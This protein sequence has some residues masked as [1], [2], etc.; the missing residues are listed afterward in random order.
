M[1]TVY[2]YPV[3]HF[4]REDDGSQPIAGLCI[5]SWRCDWGS[6]ASCTEHTCIFKQ[7][8]INTQSC[9][10]SCFWL[11]SWVLPSWV[12]NLQPWLFK[13][14]LLASELTGWTLPVWSGQVLPVVALVSSHQST[15]YILVTVV[16]LFLFFNRQFCSIH[17]EK[18]EEVDLNI[19][20]CPEV[21]GSSPAVAI[22][23]SWSP[24][25][26]KHTNSSG[27]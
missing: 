5:S 3:G 18:K 10:F 12:L 15:C 23:A 1:A 24:L 2:I 17:L 25:S 26:L 7:V 27:C 11:T 9:L 13:L 19:P 6:S 14:L 4:V 8:H 20:R 16:V 21:V 22:V